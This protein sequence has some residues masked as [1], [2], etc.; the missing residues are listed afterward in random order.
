MSSAGWA[1]P[2]LVW[3]PSRKASK[4][5]DPFGDEPPEKARWKRYLAP[6]LVVIGLVA[7]GVV[8]ITKISSGDKRHVPPG[9]DHDGQ[10]PAAAAAAPAP[11]ADEHA[12]AVG[13]TAADGTADDQG[14]AGPAPSRRRMN[15]PWARESRE[16]ARTA[17][18]WAARPATGESAARR[19]TAANGAGT[20]ARC[21]A[22]SSKRCSGTGKRARRG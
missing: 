10:P 14:R 8:L 11:A 3:P 9:C 12:A 20:P 17:L 16:T 22:G 13:R 18:A 6:A 7:G 1:F 15:R 21:R 5:D 4:M 2:R 19:A